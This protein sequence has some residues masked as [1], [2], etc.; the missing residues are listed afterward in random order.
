MVCFHNS[1]HPNSASLEVGILILSPF[2]HLQVPGVYTLATRNSAS[3][4][5][6][7]GTQSSILPVILPLSS[8]CGSDEHPPD[9]LDERVDVSP[10]ATSAGTYDMLL[11][12]ASS[13]GI[14]ISWFLGDAVFWLKIKTVLIYNDKPIPVPSALLFSSLSNHSNHVCVF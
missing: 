8:I 5:M 13:Y 11:L 12:W 1:S 10:N 9:S 3:G 2:D 6:V 7:S 4:R 14:C